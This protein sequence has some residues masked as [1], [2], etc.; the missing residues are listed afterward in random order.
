MH[1]YNAV[2]NQDAGKSPGLAGQ[3]HPIS[4]VY[5]TS[6]ENTK[7]FNCVNQRHINQTAS[8]SN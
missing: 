5:T 7:T 6:S 4:A 8:T 2:L 1:C 3:K